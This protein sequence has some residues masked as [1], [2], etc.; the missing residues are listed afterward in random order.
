M[1]LD[2]CP[3]D[4]GKS[5]DEFRVVAGAL[6]QNHH[7]HHHHRQV[8]RFPTRHRC[9]HCRTARSSLFF[10]IRQNPL[11]DRMPQTQQHSNTKRSLFIRKN[12]KNELREGGKAL[13]AMERLLNHTRDRMNAAAVAYARSLRGAS[14]EY[15][16]FCVGTT[17]RFFFEYSNFLGAKKW[18]VQING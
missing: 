3:P 17:T 6:S 14:A 18:F 1:I 5:D 13:G 7:R 2:E 8:S 4:T 10:I 12:V 9:I 15:E 11:P 16:P